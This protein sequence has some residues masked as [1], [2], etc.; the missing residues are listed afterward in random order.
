MPIVIEADRVER[1]REKNK[2]RRRKQRQNK[3]AGREAEERRHARL[4]AGEEQGNE[5][6]EI[7]DQEAVTQDLL[8]PKK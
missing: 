2:E 7:G 1:G 3:R 4:G 6:A 5:S 8:N